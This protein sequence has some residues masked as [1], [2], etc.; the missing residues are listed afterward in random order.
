MKNWYKSIRSKIGCLLF[1]SYDLCQ[2]KQQFLWL[3]CFFLFFLLRWA[4]FILLVIGLVVSS[5]CA[6]VEYSLVT[7]Q[8]EFIF[9][10]DEREIKIG[11]S[12]SRRIEKRFKLSED[13]FL[14][15]KIEQI[16]SKIARVCDRKQIPFYF[17]VLKEDKPNAFALPGG[18]VYVNE[19]IMDLI[20]SD[21]EL[22]CVLAHEV[23]HI[24]ARHSIKRLQGLYGYSLLKILSA[25]AGRQAGWDPRIDRAIA[26]LFL[27]YS[28]EDEI[29][30]DKLAVKY[31]FNAGYNPEAMLTFLKK[32]Q[33][34][35]REQPIK[36][37]SYARTHPYITERI[38]AVKEEVWGE[39]EFID[40]INTP[41]ASD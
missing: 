36:R 34:Y 4:K 22:A 16:G 17:Q 11:Q 24:V 25:T 15:E 18:F 32:L 27:A 6:R 40:F 1:R 37:L 29:L 8:E 10:S 14:K 23:G 26:E 13:K 20:E 19:G 3:N 7:G 35:H 2:L 38:K 12:L 28:R 33:K 21:D 41:D 30:A 31:A 39:I 9:I 5:G